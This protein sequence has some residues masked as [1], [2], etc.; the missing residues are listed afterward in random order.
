VTLKYKLST[1]LA[2]MRNRALAVS[3]FSLLLGCEAAG[4]PNEPVV[5]LSSTF[6]VSPATASVAFGQTAQ[7]T[8]TPEDANGNALTGKVVTWATSN[9]AIATVS[10]SGLVTAILTGTATITATSGGQSGTA[11]V[12]VIAAPVAS[13]VVSP[14]TSSVTV[15]QTAQ[16]T[17]TPEDASGNPLTGPVVTWTTS[18][19]TVATVSSSGLVTAV[20]AGAA[21]ITATSAGRS[22]TA[23]VA[24]TPATSAGPWPNDPYSQG[25]SGWQL[26]TDYGFTDPIPSGSGSCQELGTSGW[27]LNNPSTVLSEITDP[28]APH[29]GQP[30]WT[31]S[32]VQFDY[33]TG[34]VAGSA[35]GTL[36]YGPESCGSGAWPNGGTS[37]TYVA[38]WFKLSSNWYGEGS[39]VNK[40]GEVWDNYATHGTYI[41]V[42]HGAGTAPLDTWNEVEGATIPNGVTA[43][44][45][46]VNYTPITLGQWHLYEV[47]WTYTAS[48][49]PGT[50][51]YQRWLDGVLQASYTNTPVQG[52]GIDTYQIYPC[53]GG[54]GDTLTE[55]QQ[56]YISH[57]RI[58]GHP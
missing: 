55:T 25:A 41:D 1:R 51:N 3:V 37:Q 42:A 36:S 23:T 49:A 32:V 40:L 9:A 15:G 13:V 18:S 58:T 10:G 53:W 30:G 39:G 46:N 4:T 43:L 5:T 7:L 20:A 19:A 16:L 24:V 44:P 2:L 48:G 35:P 8:A 11:S 17:A 28:T 57:V 52:S 56:L 31:S 34:F 47:L 54:V 33:P 27:S 14:A 6:V 45:N 22:A 29:T 38:F 21:T 50:A 26:I 12:T